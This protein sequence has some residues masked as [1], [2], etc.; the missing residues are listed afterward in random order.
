MSVKYN[1]IDPW[2][3]ENKIKTIKDFKISSE[4]WLKAGGIVKNFITPEN[5]EDCK[6]ILILF[7]ILNFKNLNK[8]WIL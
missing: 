2:L 8:V 4:S 6:K 3:V 5:V 7:Y 1:L